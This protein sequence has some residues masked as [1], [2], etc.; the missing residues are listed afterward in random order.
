MAQELLCSTL[1]LGTAAFML[2]PKSKDVVQLRW[3]HV[4]V[5]RSKEKAGNQQDPENGASACRATF[6]LIIRI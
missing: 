3:V 6:I 2:H 4:M 1:L 5:G